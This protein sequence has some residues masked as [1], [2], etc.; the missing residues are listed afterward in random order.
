MTRYGFDINETF[1]PETRHLP[2]EQF[3]LRDLHNADKDWKLWL[4]EIEREFRY[5][6]INTPPD[7]KDALIIFGGREIAYLE[8]YLPEPDGKLDEYQKL[9]EKLN[10]YFSPRKNK[11]LARYLFQKL[12]PRPGERTVAYAARLREKAEDCKFGDNY[13]ERLLEQLI[14]TVRNDNLIQKCFRKEWTLSEF[15]RQADEE[16]IISLQIAD[17]RYNE[18]E[19]EVRRHDFQ[20]TCL[21]NEDSPC[22]YCGL[23][24]VHIKGR[25]CPAYSKRCYKCNKRDHFAVVCRTKLHRNEGIYTPHNFVS[26]T[27][28]FKLKRTELESRIKEESDNKIPAKYVGHLKMRRV[29]QKE[30]NRSLYRTRDAHS[31]RLQECDKIINVTKHLNVQKVNKLVRTS[32]RKKSYSEQSLNDD[33]TAEHCKSHERSSREDEIHLEIKDLKEVVKKWE[34]RY[35]YLERTVSSIKQKS[36]VNENK[37]KHTPPNMHTKCFK[38][39]RKV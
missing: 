21:N 23:S 12:R 6:R 37:T 16:E 10:T 39:R 25:G 2:I 38:E 5:F 18:S 20:Q 8:K 11:Y 15:L 3:K 9:R 35:R 31:A 34:N 29:K 19:N 36:R 1:I 32:K 22:G 28:M 7:K 17:M 27:S 13:E 24:G 33:K 26:E 30:D 4:E 14:V